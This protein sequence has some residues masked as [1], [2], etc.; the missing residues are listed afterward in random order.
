MDG[1][2]RAAALCPSPVGE[3]CLGG[4]GWVVMDMF[5]PGEAFGERKWKGKR[6]RGETGGGGWSGALNRLGGTQGLAARCRPTST[7]VRSVLMT[8]KDHRWVLVVVRWIGTAFGGEYLGFGT[9][10]GRWT[11][12][13]ICSQADWSGPVL[14]D[15]T[16]KDKNDNE[17]NN[18]EQNNPMGS[19]QS[20]IF[21]L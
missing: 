2:E 3:V 16:N 4:I 9:G 18:D 15:L 10:G 6:Q 17:D 5:S 20:L 13:V 21:F 11:G 1:G 14:Y 12:I 19:N 8:V 7:R